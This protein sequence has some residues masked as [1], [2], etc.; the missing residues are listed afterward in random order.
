MKMGFRSQCIGGSA[1]AAAMNRQVGRVSKDECLFSFIHD[2]G[3]SSS[4]KNSV[5]IG[6]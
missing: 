4:D 2:S 1:N 5:K 3:R 6:E